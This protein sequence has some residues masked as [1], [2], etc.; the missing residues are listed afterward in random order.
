[1]SV[2]HRNPACVAGLFL[3]VGCGLV[4]APPVSAQPGVTPA[5]VSAAAPVA[6]DIPAQ[7]LAEALIEFG[8][9]SHQE[10][11]YSN[12]DV[13]GK[14]GNAVSG[15]LSRVDAMAALL[16]GTGLEFEQTPSGGMMVGERATLDAQRAARAAAAAQGDGASPPVRPLRQRWTPERPRIPR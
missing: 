16:A 7:G 5:S 14:S 15:S 10:L 8:R 13:A 4:V 9:Q 2:L 12:D 1:M 3:A 6:F 11:F